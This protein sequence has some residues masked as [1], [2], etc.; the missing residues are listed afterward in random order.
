MR[1]QGEQ[2]KEPQRRL[3]VGSRPRTTK[4]EKTARLAWLLWGLWAG[5][6]LRQPTSL[7][8]QFF[9]CCV[10]CLLLHQLIIKEKTSEPF[11]F[12]YSSFGLFLSFINY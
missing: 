11:S 12:I 4:E 5:G 10:A 2:S 9:D 8:N 6:H 3:S 1:E 7:H